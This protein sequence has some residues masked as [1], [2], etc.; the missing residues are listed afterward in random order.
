MYRP[1][2]YT[3]VSIGMIMCRINNKTRRPEAIMVRSRYTYAY[4]EFIHGHYS[5]R[6][7]RMIQILFN[8]MSIDERLDIY[9]LN[10]DQ[11]WYRIWLTAEHREL[12]FSKLAKFHEIWLKDDMGKLLRKM[13]CSAQGSKDM[14]WEFPKGKRQTTYEADIQCAIREFTEETN[15]SKNCY[16]LLPNFK[17]RDTYV[18]MGVKYVNIYYVAI[19][20]RKFADPGSTISIRQLTQVAEVADVRWMD[21]EQIR[22]LQG[23][24]GRNLEKIARPAFNFIKR[25]A[26]GNTMYNLP[27]NEAGVGRQAAYFG[28]EL[29]RKPK[30]L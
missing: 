2:T 20:R 26:Q 8:Q 25:W 15:I 9:S 1:S 23:P 17:R 3:K 29:S 12:Y 19:Q 7:L 13:V 24:V 27:F 18:H 11:M 10:F 28:L 21:I 4:S 14:H 6:N 5:R 22:L 16:Q 30:K